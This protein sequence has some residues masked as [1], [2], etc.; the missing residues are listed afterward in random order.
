MV[1][2]NTTPEAKAK[3]RAAARTI[4]QQIADLQAKAKAKQDKVEAKAKAEL[5]AVQAKIVEAETKLA[6]LYKQ[7]TEAKEILG[8]D[9]EEVVDITAYPVSDALVN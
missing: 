5:A 3:P 4:E 2:E 7:R 6:V 9:D 1:K 8:I